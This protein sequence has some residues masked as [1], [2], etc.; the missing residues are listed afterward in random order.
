LVFTSTSRIDRVVTLLNELPVAQPGIESCPSDAGNRVRLAFYDR[1]GSAPSAIADVNPEGCSTVQLTLAGVS[2][3][4]LAGGALPGSP[5]PP[6]APLLTQ[7]QRILG[8]KLDVERRPEATPAR[9]SRR[10]A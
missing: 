3:P 8:V 2:Q 1:R 4:P 10:T 7:L 6:P 5:L 9:P